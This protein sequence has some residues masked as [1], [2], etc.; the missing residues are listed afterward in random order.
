MAVDQ[1]CQTL[2]IDPK[3]KTVQENLEA[4]I[5][6]SK[7]PAAQ[8]SDALLLE[9]LLSY[10]EN[11]QERVSYLTFKRNLLRDQ[12][13]ESG[14]GKN[15]LL[16][17][18]VD[19]RDN[20]SGSRENF[21]YQK[22]TFF[23]RISPLVLINNLLSKEKV[24]LA[25]HVH[26]LQSQYDWLQAI[27]K[28][29][30]D[31]PSFYLEKSHMAGIPEF[32]QDATKT[33]PL[34]AEID[35]S[36]GKQTDGKFS[37]GLKHRGESGFDEGKMEKAVAL[38]THENKM[39]EANKGNMGQYKDGTGAMS[40][41]IDELEEKTGKEDR[42]LNDLERQVVD[43]SLKLSETEIQLSEKAEAVDFLKEQLN[44]AEQRF[45]LGQ[46][47]IQE[48]DEEM[49]SVQEDLR[50]MQLRSKDKAMDWNH[51][52]AR[53]DQF[54]E[55][56]KIQLS[57]ADKQKQELKDKVALKDRQLAELEAFLEISR[58]NLAD[59]NQQ[60]IE[61]IGNL[62]VMK[63][64]L[65]EVQAKVSSDQEIIRKYYKEMMDLRDGLDSAAFATK[66]SP[67]EVNALL[68]KKDKELKELNAFLNIYR[69]G[70]GDAKRVIEQ[71]NAQ[72]G[73]LERTLSHL[74]NR[75]ALH[76][77]QQENK[78]YRINILKEKLLSEKDKRERRNINLRNVL[79]QKDEEIN[80]LKER[81]WRAQ[82][83]LQAA[84]R[85]LQEKI[86]YL[87][88]AKKELA[89]LRKQMDSD[90]TMA[91]AED[92]AF[93]DEKLHEL[94]GIL[95][96]YKGR[97]FDEVRT[98]REKT[99]SISALEKDLKTLENQLDQKNEALVKTQNDLRDLEDQLTVMK[100]E[101]LRLKGRPQDNTFQ[102]NDVNRQLEEMQ[103]KF[104]EIN[105]FLLEN[106]Y[107]SDRIKSRLVVQ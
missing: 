98:A 55:G 52:I 77:N 19:M 54:L 4:I 44:E 90:R 104:R 92:P 95:S 42:K 23:N 76:V 67:E 24:Q 36:E 18:L 99:A 87:N 40:V 20:I 14:Y 78:D 25:V 93:Y 57:E 107:D 75:M 26:S 5:A 27:Q 34:V 60:L 39:E 56:L 43:L 3:N 85:A 79:L 73:S 32:H 63:E 100:Q 102:N 103:S 7:L 65:N 69:Q 29:E 11:L 33:Y 47:I 66:K 96:I 45:V 88:Y 22:Q 101:L 91:V 53:K 64:K 62:R 97:L 35:L 86:A 41:E 30:N 10:I 61:K 70:L 6:H 21:S 16:K 12:L 13:I 46:R 51:T 38:Q 106:L 68:E 58:E 15:A 49:K 48:K 81:L 37:S 71:K 1:F 80:D 59:S 82:R 83:S 28:G 2:S 9:D 72:L 50:M 84:N 17:G 105:D 94:S 8:K 89:L 74:Q 31:L